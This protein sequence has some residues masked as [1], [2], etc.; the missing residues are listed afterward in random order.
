MAR[1]KIR[2]NNSNNNNDIK[3]KKYEN[4]NSNY[5]SI[6]NS[7]VVKSIF[8][9]GKIKFFDY[10][11]EFG[12]KNFHTPQ[13]FN[14]QLSHQNS[15]GVC[16]Q[17][18]WNESNSSLNLNFNNECFGN[19]FPI[20]AKSI[21]FRDYIRTDTIINQGFR[22]SYSFDVS[23]FNLT[24][25]NSLSFVMHS[26]MSDLTSDDQYQYGFANVVHTLAVELSKSYEDYRLFIRVHN[27]KSKENLFNTE[28]PKSLFAPTG[29]NN[30]FVIMFNHESLSISVNFNGN[31]LTHLPFNFKEINNQVDHL[32]SYFGI[33]A[34]STQ[35]SIILLDNIQLSSESSEPQTQVSEVAVEQTTDEQDQDHSKP[36]SRNQLIKKCLVRNIVLRRYIKSFLPLIYLHPSHMIAL[37]NAQ[38]LAGSLM[39]T[40]PY[41]SQV[42]VC[43]SRNRL[44]IGAGFFCRFKIRIDGGGA[45][46][47][48]F[49]IH[50]AP[51]GANHIDMKQVGGNLGYSGIPNSL[52]IEFDTYYNED[53]DEN[54]SH[55]SIHSDGTE[56]NTSLFE[57]SLSY[58]DIRPMNDGRSLDVVV[59]YSEA[60]GVL[61]VFIDNKSIATDEDFNLSEFIGLENN[62]AYVGFTASTGDAS[63]YHFVEQFE[64]YRL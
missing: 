17:S 12:Q 47:M 23:K 59:R 44:N 34:R 28:L 51:E 18:K 6:I 36:S 45:D 26:V 25:N 39:L 43:W 32:F 40:G 10:F 63:Q 24:G 2:T 57:S 62:L 53:C 14:Q 13:Y 4:N 21:W 61:E 58:E 29:Q 37:G 48:A 55:V 50:N 27:L 15:F 1:K 41:R 56:P 31:L 8:D 52:A 9:D 54:D 35:G 46:G 20:V 19:M 30:S 7:E 3:I 5:T 22:F 33:V 42:G 16:H 49:V 11:K 64:I 38:W 60:A